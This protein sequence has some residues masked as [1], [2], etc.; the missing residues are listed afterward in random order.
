MHRH[1]GNRPPGRRRSIFRVTPKIVQEM[2][3]LS[4]STPYI[5][6]P[7]H[8]HV[9]HFVQSSRAAVMFT[10]VITFLEDVIEV[11]RYLGDGAG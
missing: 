9:V 7:C 3:K 11:Y 2:T 10:M 5:D 4:P 6:Y 1:D 8:K